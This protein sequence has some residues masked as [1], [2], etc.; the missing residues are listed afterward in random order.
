MVEYGAN[1]KRY[2]ITF[3]TYIY[4]KRS[5]IATCLFVYVFRKRS[6]ESKGRRDR[7]LERLGRE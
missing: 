4:I 5:R 1:Y 2:C 6:K 7:S 3:N